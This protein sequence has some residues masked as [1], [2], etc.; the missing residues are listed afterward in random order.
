MLDIIKLLIE[1]LAKVGIVS[2]D[3]GL[4]FYSLLKTVLHWSDYSYFI[5][6]NIL[7]F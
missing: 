5:A 2:G 6:N 4:W 1:H 3:L 7:Q